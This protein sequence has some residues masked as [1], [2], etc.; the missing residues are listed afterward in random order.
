[1]EL[2]IIRRYRI[3]FNIFEKFY[4]KNLIINLLWSSTT[5]TCT[6]LVHSLQIIIKFKYVFITVYN[7]E[8]NIYDYIS[9]TF[10]LRSNNVKYE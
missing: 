4:I 6:K 8:G 5:E 10:E 7:N 2:E 1:M 3:P 9:D